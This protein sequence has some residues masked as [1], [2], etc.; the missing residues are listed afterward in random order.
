LT[1][2]LPPESN[3]SNAIL[4]KCYAVPGGTPGGKQRCIP[5]DER[6]SAEKQ[7]THPHFAG[8]FRVLRC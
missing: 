7:I 5:T 2:L 1:P 3:G 4:H 8:I 6:L